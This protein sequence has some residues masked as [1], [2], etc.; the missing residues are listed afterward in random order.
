MKSPFVKFVTLVAL[1]SSLLVACGKN[2]KVGG[3]G[4][5]TANGVYSPFGVGSIYSSGMSTGLGTLDSLIQQI[6]C[7]QTGSDQRVALTFICSNGACQRSGVSPYNS[8]NVRLGRTT[9]GDIAIVKYINSMQAEMTYLMCVDGLFNPQ[10]A[11][12][13]NMSGLQIKNS[14][15][16]QNGPV[17]QFIAD[18][19][20]SIPQVS[21]YAQGGMIKAVFY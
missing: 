8:G 5:G 21:G 7:M 14:N 12:S 4:V 17:G 9:Y 6:H 10:T 19:W 18:V 15:V 13:I 20:F 16:T 1:A 3:A 2:N 11:P